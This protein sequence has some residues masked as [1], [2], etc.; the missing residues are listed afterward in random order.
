VRYP[1]VGGGSVDD[2]QPFMV[3]QPFGI[4]MAH[5]GNLTNFGELKR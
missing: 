4:S 5:N 3:K 2:T 1:T